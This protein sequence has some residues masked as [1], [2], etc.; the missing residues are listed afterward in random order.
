MTIKHTKIPLRER[1]ISVINSPLS[2]IGNEALDAF[3]NLPGVENWYPENI[4]GLEISKAFDIGL[5]FALLADNDSVED[6]RKIVGSSIE[7]GEEV[8]NS[9]MSEVHVGSILSN[10]G[11]KTEFI[12]RQA[13]PTSDIQAIWT[14]E[15]KVN[16]EVVRG[17]IRHLHKAVKKGLE[18][19]CGALQPGDMSWNF[20]GFFADAS[21]SNDLSAMFESAIKLVP[22]ESFD[23]PGKWHIRAVA[24]EDRDV[25]VGGNN[26]ELFA[27]EWWPTG[28]PAYFATGS[29]IGSSGNPVVLFRSLIPLASYRN[30]ILRKATS[31]QCQPGNSYLIA[32]DVS[33]L[34]RAHERIVEELTKD[35]EVWTHVSAVL[36]FEPRFYFGTLNKEYIISL[37]RNPYAAITIPPELIHLASGQKFSNVFKIAES[38]P[39]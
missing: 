4:Y 36:L 8:P 25:V 32:L 24:I 11:A 31:G 28:E 38:D 3:V 30:P 21:N 37:H 26:V 19:F 1:I 23:E 9:L 34:P 22:G 5:P 27:P 18:S 39:N 13:H 16:V 7:R 2:K 6:H 20:I 35:F 29:L 14:N 33:E 12:P 17:D 10:W 15:T